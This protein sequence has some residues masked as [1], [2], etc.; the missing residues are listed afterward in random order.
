MLTG[1]YIITDGNRAGQLLKRCEAALQGGATVLQY[2][3]KTLSTEEKLS[4]LAQL[5]PLCQRYSIPLIVND[6]AEL[7]LASDADGV[8]L[9]Q[10][11][12]S[13]SRARALLG[14]DKIIGVSTRTIAQA[15]Q[16]EAD[17]ADYIGLGAMYTTASKFDAERVGVERLREVRAAV[18][19]PTV[20]MGGID[21]DNAAPLID[22]GADA[23]A[24]ISA[25]MTAPEPVWAARELALL[26]NRRLDFPRGRVLTIAGSDSGGG[27]GVQADL[28]T[29]TLLG[30]Y[31]MS[32]ITALTAQNTCGVLAVHAP[33]PEFVT[34]QIDA[35]LN[36][37][38]CDTV[39]TGML[40]SSELLRRAAKAIRERQ[41]VAII[42]PVM[43]AKG[44]A[45]LLQEEA[46]RAL[47]ED[48]IPLAYLLTP[49]LP[50]AEALTGQQIRNVE[51]MEQAAHALQA[52]GARNV[53]VKG[54]HLKE[55]EAIDLLLD[56]NTLHRFS[57]P[58]I[59]TGNT[60][61]TGCTYASAVA[62]YL[63]Q[64]EPLPNAVHQAKIFL[65]HAI[66]TTRPLGKGH[67]PVNHWQGAKK[68]TQSA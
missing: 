59:N 27:A 23:V 62:T 20:A 26:F 44:G 6:S 57:A 31:G 54:G 41:L 5:K 17:G 16:A 50:E 53:L 8:H 58:R 34:A 43:I 47:R 29:T 11:D 2:R 22:A 38:G 12:G 1:V 4:E 67:G 60:H 56:G 35:V 40:F 68:I 24:V 33:P 30:S 42:D 46:L 25:V 21:R 32:V 18:K 61:G 28:K 65:S 3:E 66:A 15:R 49:N 48:L 36:D 39:K 13:V 64:G 14:P 55:G 19:H 52:L 45:A 9:G 7:A 51:E 37:I 10:K 63:A